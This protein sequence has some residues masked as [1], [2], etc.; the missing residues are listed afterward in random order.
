MMM[1]IKRKETRRYGKEG[2]GK[3]EKEREDDGEDQT[4]RPPDKA[5]L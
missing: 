3:S 2:R 5:N 4:D 1:M